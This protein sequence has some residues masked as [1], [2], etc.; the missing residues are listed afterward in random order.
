MSPRQLA[1]IAIAFGVLLLL[2]GAAALARRRESIPPAADR[3]T[4]PHVARNA[5]DSVHIDRPGDTTVL[6]RRDTVWRANGHP[7]SAQAVSD[8]FAALAD[9]AP[10]SELVA[11]RRASQP[12]LGVDSVGGTRVRIFGKGRTLADF[13]AGHRTPDLGGI[14]LRRSGQE[15]SYLVRGGLA[16][17]LDRSGSEW[18]DRRIAGVPA[19]SIAAVEVSRGARH[20]ALRRSAGRWGLAPGGAADSGA[21]ASLLGRY[22]TIEAAGFASPA[23]AD[24]ARFERPDRRVRLLREDGTPLLALQFDSTGTGFWVRPDTAKTVYKL[25]A[26]TADQLTPADSTLRVRASRASDSSRSG[27]RPGS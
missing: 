21:V 5:V 9:T 3:F 23:Q 17:A 12:G 22:R 24:S 6:V 13:V 26:W 16:A 4:L 7:S 27:R 18:R 15:V 14:Y 11:E 10:A 1:R 19:E 20:Y 25:E 8:F 2:W